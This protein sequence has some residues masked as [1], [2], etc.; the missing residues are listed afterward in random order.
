MN[1]VYANATAREKEKL[2]HEYLPLVK[3]IARG[4][5]RRSTDPVED[6][7]QVGSIGLLEAIERYES[8]H[9]TAFKTYAIHFITG[10]I[11]HYLRDR[12]SLVR[13]PRAL[14]ELSYRLRV[15][16]QELNHALGRDATAEE[17]AEALSITP[18]QVR[19]A[20]V[21]DRRVSVMWLDQQAEGDDEEQPTLLHTLADP[22]TQHDDRDERLMLQEAIRRLPDNLA[23]LVHLRYVEDLTQ[24]ELARRMDISQMEVSR[25][26]RKAEKQIRA[27]TMAPAI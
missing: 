14:Q 3:K 11:R 21:Y 27:I 19:E 24:A 20:K 7:I 10:H 25:R 26:L 23:E 2:V 8:G 1:K 13:G 22:S 18:E 16:T 15:V 12:Q 9:S 4:L 5:A 6:L 17:L